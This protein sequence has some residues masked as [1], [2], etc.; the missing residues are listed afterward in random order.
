MCTLGMLRDNA[1]KC[2]WILSKQFR[3]CKKV[4]LKNKNHLKEIILYKNFNFL[5]LLIL[6]KKKQMLILLFIYIAMLSF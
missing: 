5:K 1:L 2:E 4:H 3:I 6:L